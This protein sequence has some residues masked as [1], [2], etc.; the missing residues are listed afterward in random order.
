MQS[1]SYI[2]FNDLKLETLAEKLTNKHFISQVINGVHKVNF[3]EYINLEGI[4]E[5]KQLLRLKPKG[6]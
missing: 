1:R 4:E 5:A 6:P 3:F 2:K